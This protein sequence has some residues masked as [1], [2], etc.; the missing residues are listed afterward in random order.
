MEEMAERVALS[1]GVGEG[2]PGHMTRAQ[3]RALIASDSSDDESQPPISEA[4]TPEAPAATAAIESREAS[5]PPS[6][7]PQT[8]ATTAEGGDPADPSGGTPARTRYARTD[9][10]DETNGKSL[11]EL[12]DASHHVDEALARRLDP[13]GTASGTPS[14]PTGGGGGGGGGSKWKVVRQKM[15]KRHSKWNFHFGRMSV[16]DDLDNVATVDA[17]GVLGMQEAHE[18]AKKEKWFLFPEGTPRRVWD[19]WLLVLIFYVA[20]A[21]P[22]RIGFRIEVEVGCTTLRCTSLPLRAPA[23]T[24]YCKTSRFSFSLDC[25]TN[26]QLERV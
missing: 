21:I 17:H 16:V 13:D 8:E 23:I 1:G 9:D 11:G 2:S 6:Q 25:P 20:I 26:Y 14:S 3:A 22:M 18:Q 24:R 10:D 15:I 12:R 5:A 4:P 19:V 7:Q